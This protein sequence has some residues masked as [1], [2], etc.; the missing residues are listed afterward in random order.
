MQLYQKWICN[1]AIPTVKSGKNSAALIIGS[2]L[3]M[4]QT[5]CHSSQTA[6]PSGKFII[7]AAS[8][9]Q[10]VMGKVGDAFKRETNIDLVINYGS[11]GTLAEQI[12]NGAS[13]DL[14]AAAN[15]KTILDLEKGGSIV[16]GSE[17]VY[18]Q[19]RLILWS[20]AGNKINSLEYLLK[21][22]VKHIS[23][24]DPGHAPYGTAAKEALIAA[25]IWDRV[26][27]KIVYA[28]NVKQALTYAE[29]G[30]VDVAITA[31]SLSPV[32]GSKWLI[33]EHLHSPLLQTI[34]ITAKCL[35]PDEA[36]KLEKFLIS[37]AGRKILREG[38]FTLPET[39]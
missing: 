2:S 23:I 35:K 10:L 15:Q 14:F 8:D 3:G 16:L 7:S 13:V 33:P 31:N 11:T 24:A 27:G 1:L 17:V 21:P 4:M 25:G 18:A 6:K 32:S 29:T 34:G 36:R 12:R 37:P 38:G 5:G 22:E 19:G 9:L 39:K 30:D 28:D 20:K 26:K